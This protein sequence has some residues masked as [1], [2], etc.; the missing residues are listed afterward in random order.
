MS[1][2]VHLLFGFALA[3]GSAGRGLSGQTNLIA[4]EAAWFG[5]GA[6]GEERVVPYI[7]ASGRQS[8]SIYGM[9]LDVM[10][11]AWIDLDDPRSSLVNVE[12]I[13]VKEWDSSEFR[14]GVGDVPWGISELRSPVD[15][16]VPRGVLW[17]GLDGPRLS[18][19]LVGLTLFG[20]WGNLEA[21]VLP[22]S[23]PLYLG[24]HVTETWGEFTLRSTEEWGDHV[25][26]G[27]RFSRTLGPVDLAVSY[28][29]GRDRSLW[30]ERG[31]DGDAPLRAPRIRQVGYELQW[32]TGSLVLRTEG[33]VGWRDGADEVR[34]ITG[35]E[36]YPAPYLSFVLEQGLASPDRD[37]RTPLADDLLIAGQLTAEDLRLE[38]R[39]F[40]DP[41][42]GNR[43]Y[44]VVMGWRIGEF[45]SLE[46]EIAGSAANP[47]REPALAIRQPGVLL[48]SLVRYF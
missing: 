13:L 35:G 29:D 15:V 39:L 14:L 1:H 3:V 26:G 34:V 17:N 10:G 41:G 16:M 36:W 21:I 11:S 12:A 37:A 31:P 7:R 38:A 43:H 30:A 28:I 18:Q 20:G 32:A 9:P 23:R 25:S 27:A 45:T 47:A 19:P 24:G 8:V 22:Y 5:G 2:R 6:G 44:F 42:S 4:V 46:V 33:A 40:V 48:L